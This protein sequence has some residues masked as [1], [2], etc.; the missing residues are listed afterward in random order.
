[1]LKINSERLCESLI[2]MAAIGDTATGRCRRLTL[3][4]EDAAGRAL[5]SQWCTK[6]A[7]TLS[8]DMMGNLFV[9][10]AGKRVDAAP[11]AQR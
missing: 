4:A 3:T 7:L 5:F 11:V 2:D 8:S 6:A 10:S 9:R 1:M